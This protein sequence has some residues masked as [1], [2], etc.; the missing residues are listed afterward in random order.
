MTITAKF[1]GACPCCNGRINPG[2]KVEWSKGEKARH[3]SCS[4]SSATA[5]ARPSSPVSA[6]RAPRTTCVQCG[7]S[8]DR[9]QVSHGFKFCSRDCANDRKL[10]GQSGYVNGVWHQGEDD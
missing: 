1:P 2:D 8:L 3:A 7:C 10:G 6:R 9:Y 4:S 5:S